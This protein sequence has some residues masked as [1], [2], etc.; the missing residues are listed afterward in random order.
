MTDRE[1]AGLLGH[2]RTVRHGRGVPPHLTV[3]WFNPE[4]ARVMSENEYADG[5]V[6]QTEYVYDGAGRLR[7]TR[8][9]EEDGSRTYEYDARGRLV[10][11]CLEADET[12]QVCEEIRYHADGGKSRIEYLSPPDGERSHGYRIEGTDQFVLAQGAATITTNYDAAGHPVEVLAHNTEKKLL[13]KT[14]LRCDPAGRVIEMVNQVGDTSAFTGV[15]EMAGLPAEMRN[16]FGRIFAPGSVMGRTS[17]TY[18]ECGRCVE[19]ISSDPFSER[20]DKSTYDQQGNRLTEIRYEERHDIEIDDS[21][22]IIGARERNSSVFETRFE[23]DYDE[24]GNWTKCTTYVRDDPAKE[25]RNSGVEHRTIT[26]Y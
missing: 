14:V 21:G 8:S 26:Y 1:K 20:S 23:Y 10:R 15:P 18:D 24:R 19:Q 17:F 11:V 12:K 2:V 6:S 13:L 25:F 9:D 4:G 7:E 22:H 3:E 5:S 16:V